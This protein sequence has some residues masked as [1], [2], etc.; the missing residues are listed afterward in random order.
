[1]PGSSL[2]LSIQKLLTAAADPN[3]ASQMQRYMKSEMPYHGVPMSQV[4]RIARAALQE[5][6][7][8]TAAAWKKEVLALWNGAR[9]REERYVAL[10]LCSD[11]R[12]VAFQTPAALSLY[13]KLIVSGAWWDLVDEL[14]TRRVAAI[15]AAYPKAMKPK[16]RRWSRDRNIWKRRTAILCQLYFKSA[17]DRLLL[18]DCLEPSIDSEEFFLRKAIGWALRQ[19]ARTNPAWVRAYVKEHEQR[20]SGLSRREAL[21]HL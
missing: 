3:R 7:L 20:L 14:A 4:R 1:M 17:T 16:M 2:L 15:L 8:L 10:V 18:R 5:I 13:E 21:K 6:D 11:K 19:Y 12:A 9:F